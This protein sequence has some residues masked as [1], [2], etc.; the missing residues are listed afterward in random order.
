MHSRK[1]IVTLVT[2]AL[3][4]LGIGA[5]AAI[6]HDNSPKPVTAADCTS[7]GD[8]QDAVEA[9]KDVAEAADEGRR[10]SRHRRG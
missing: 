9:A 10:G 3:L 5:T 8:E 6:A 7:A 4:L 2:S 1:L